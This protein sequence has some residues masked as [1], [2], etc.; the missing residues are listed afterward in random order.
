[1]GGMRWM[2]KMV[3]GFLHEKEKE[4]KIVLLSSLGNC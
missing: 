2:V 4:D 1:M 3:V